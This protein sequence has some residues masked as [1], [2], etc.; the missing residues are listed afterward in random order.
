[1]KIIKKQTSIPI[2][3]VYGFDVSSDHPFGHPYV[4]MEYLGGRSLP[5][6]LATT[7]PPQ[8]HAKVAQQLANVFAELQTLTFSRIGR[9]WCG[10]PTNDPV[11]IIAMSW[12]ASPGPLDTSLEYFYNE[13]QSENREIMAMYPN[14]PDRLTACW[15]LK[16]ALTYMVIEDR[17]RGPFPLCHLDLHYG[18][19]L[20]DDD[21]NLTGVIDWR[22]AQAAPLEQLSMCPEFVTFPGLS[23]EENQPILDLK[24]LV[25]EAIAEME[26]EKGSLSRND[27]E[28]EAMQNANLTT[29]STYMASKSALITYRQY[30]TTVRGS[31]WAGKV[32]AG[33]TTKYNIKYSCGTDCPRC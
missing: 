1:M 13:R 17:V 29:L 7:I 19:M 10:E 33:F 11:E 32:V 28:K 22:S 3:N 4:F 20:F 2:P 6:G 24:Q 23:E 25:V 8:H 21:F 5:N 31:L 9:L 18:N 15:V 26:R 16:Q 14:D 27:R 30:M 12:H